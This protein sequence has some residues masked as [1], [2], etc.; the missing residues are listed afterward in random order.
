M[1]SM[2]F[3]STIH[4]PN[5][6]SFVHHNDLAQWHDFKNTQAFQGYPPSM[7]YETTCSQHIIKGK[8]AAL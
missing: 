8:L 3:F 5:K 6:V 1:F 2:T 7:F 4:R